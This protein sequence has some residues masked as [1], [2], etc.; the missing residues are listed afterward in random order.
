MTAAGRVGFLERPHVHDPKP[1][2]EPGQIMRR[3]FPLLLPVRLFH[4]DRVRR[5]LRV[6]DVGLEDRGKAIDGIGNHV[7]EIEI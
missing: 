6:D 7:V 1:V 3:E 2:L 4:E 5:R